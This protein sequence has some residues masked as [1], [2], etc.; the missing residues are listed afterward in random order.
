MLY[1]QHITAKTS[2]PS[3]GPLLA[4]SLLPPADSLPQIVGSEPVVKT[5]YPPLPHITGYGVAY[6]TTPSALIPSTWSTDPVE[7]LFETKTVLRDSP[8]GISLPRNMPI[9][10]ERSGGDL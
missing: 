9:A 10:L 6:I 7:A 8:S 2:S 1:N 4:Y 3:S 5:Y